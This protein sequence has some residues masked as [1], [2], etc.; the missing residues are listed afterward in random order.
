MCDPPSQ[1]NAA[2]PQAA[3]PSSHGTAAA[4]ALLA[5]ERRG[6]RRSSR[7]CPS[8]RD[9][10]STPSAPLGR[11]RAVRPGQTAA[12]RAAVAAHFRTVALAVRARRRDVRGCLSYAQ[13]ADA[14]VRG[15]KKAGDGQQDRHPK[16]ARWT[17]GIHGCSRRVKGSALRLVTG[18]GCS[19]SCSCHRRSKPPPTGRRTD[20]IP[21][22][23]CCCTA[24]RR[25]PM[26]AGCAVPERPPPSHPVD[27]RASGMRP[28]VEP[29]VLVNALSPRHLTEKVS[30]NGTPGIVIGS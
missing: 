1:R 6:V 3:A 30:E 14:Q 19:C 29:G 2:A 21:S 15:T 13:A 10:L 28:R 17:Q 27:K 16:P 26:R 8:C 4:H 9:P 12:R 23:R 5:E 7:A 11:A 24:G 22:R 18:S 20:R 25:T